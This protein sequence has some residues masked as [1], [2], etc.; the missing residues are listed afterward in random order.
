MRAVN[1]RRWWTKS[2]GRSHKPCSPLRVLLTIGLLWFIAK[3]HRSFWSQQPQEQVKQ[4]QTL[5]LCCKFQVGLEEVKTVTAPRFN[6]TRDSMQKLRSFGPLHCAKHKAECFMATSLFKN[7][8]NL[9]RELLLLYSSQ[10][11]SRGGSF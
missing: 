10:L 8:N 3:G 9:M 7:H 4:Q 1:H 5:F 11:L 6:S 2:E